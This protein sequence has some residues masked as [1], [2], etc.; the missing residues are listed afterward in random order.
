MLKLRLITSCILI[1]IVIAGL[2][3][4]SLPWFAVIMIVIS[5]LAAWE[6]TALSGIV[7][8]KK[9]VSMTLLFGLIIFIYTLSL[10]FELEWILS[11]FNLINILQV[12]LIWWT[13]ATLLVLFYP[14]SALFWP[15]SYL[16]RLIF[17]VLTLLPFFC[18]MLFLRQYNYVVD[19]H[20]GSWLILYLMLLIW[21][22]D[23]GAY[24]C[25]KMFGKHK[26]LPRVSVGKTWEGLFGGLL[27][28]GC[29]FYFLY[30]FIPFRISFSSLFVCSLSAVLISIFGDLTESMFKRAAGIKDSSNLI[31]GHGGVLD[32]IDSLT[33]AIPIF[34]SLQ[35]LLVGVF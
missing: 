6:W 34:A 28:A 5:M 4:C 20:A 25:G 21:G 10:M 13:I 15:T 31:P 33:A 14:S 19:H 22:M 9:R 29:V 17:G 12:S 1:P 23:S 27:T 30:L 7:S 11:W 24:L 26:L 35:L 16:L 8:F 3:L 32:R 2:F 18:G